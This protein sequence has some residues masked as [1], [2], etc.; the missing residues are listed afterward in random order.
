M[1][2]SRMRDADAA[3]GWAKLLVV[4]GVASWRG[5]WNTADDGS[6]EPGREPGDGERRGRRI[7]DE[8]S[9]ARDE[10]FWRLRLRS[11]VRE[12]IDGAASKFPWL[13]FDRS[14]RL[15]AESDGVDGVSG[16]GESAGVRGGVA[17]VSI[18]GGTRRWVGV[19]SSAMLLTDCDGRRLV[20]RV[21]TRSRRAVL[22]EI[23]R[24]SCRERVS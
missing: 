24:A 1:T 6:G 17:V 12:P 20:V 8:L 5:V 13:F 10:M 2:R 14:V 18:R 4:R 19:A 23:G 16:I 11:S 15:V 21:R 7:N 3:V 22:G 9:Y